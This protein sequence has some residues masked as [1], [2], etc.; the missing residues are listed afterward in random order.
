MDLMSDSELELVIAAN[1]VRKLEVVKAA[2]KEHYLVVTLTSGIER[3][4]RTAKGTHRIWASM[5][6]LVARLQSYATT[7]S[8]KLPPISLV[9]SPPRKPKDAKPGALQ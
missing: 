5:D 4:V 9:L 1:G 6:S 7:A 2:D 3:G 8:V